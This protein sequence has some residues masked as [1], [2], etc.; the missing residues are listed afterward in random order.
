MAKVPYGGPQHRLVK[1]RIGKGRELA[2]DHR[3]I[4]DRTTLFRSTIEH[5][6]TS[7]RLLVDGINQ[8]KGV[9]SYER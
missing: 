8:R 9:W 4:V 1:A 2:A 3:A 5:A 6:S 7:P